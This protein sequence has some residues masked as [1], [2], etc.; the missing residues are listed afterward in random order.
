MRAGKAGTETVWT[1]LAPRRF[2]EVEVVGACVGV[3]GSGRGKAG[4][5]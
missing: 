1:R 4:A 2:P 3:N 5:G